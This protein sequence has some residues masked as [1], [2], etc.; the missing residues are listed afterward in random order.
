MTRREGLLAEYLGIRAGELLE[1]SGL[2]PEALRDRPELVEQL[3]ERV[4]LEVLEVDRARAGAALDRC[5]AQIRVTRGLPRLGRAFVIAREYA[6]TRFHIA[7]DMY[8]VP[9]GDRP[10]HRVQVWEAN[11]FAGIL[12][13]LVVVGADG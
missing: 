12:L 5:K 13:G 9:G 4:G 10:P 11:L 1:A 8:G 3:A 2:S 7:D 6:H